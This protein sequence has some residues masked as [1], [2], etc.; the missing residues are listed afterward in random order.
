M[1]RASLISN[2]IMSKYVCFCIPIEWIVLPP[3]G[4]EVV[5]E[6]SVLSTTL[7]L[8]NT[9]IGSGILVQG[10]V[11]K[12]TGIVLAIFEYIVIGWMIYAGVDLITRCADHA[13]LFD[14][15]DIAR[16]FLGKYGAM[17]VD[18]AFVINNAGALLSYILIVGSLIDSV[19]QTFSNCNLWCC[20]VG[21]LTV[22]PILLFTVPFCLIRDFGHLA[23]ISYISIVAI[24]GSIMLVI[25]GGPLHRQQ[26]DDDADHTLLLGS[27]TGSIKAIGSIVFALGYVTG[28][29]QSYVAL[30][31]KSVAKFSAITRNT[32]LLGTAMCFVTGLM[33]YL[34]FGSAT[35]SN[36]LENFDSAV[37]AAF[38]LVVALHLILYIPG[39]FV[40]LREA[41]W[42][43]YDVN[44]H[45]QSDTQ[46]VVLTLLLILSIT[47][48]AVLLQL[49]ASNSDALAIV[50]DVTGGM[51]GSVL[52]FT[53]PA[54]IGLK[55]F[56]EDRAL[57]WRCWA[58]LVF[59]AYIII[60]V[61][62]SY[63]L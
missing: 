29:F 60:T 33:G 11:F 46:F 10:Y 35:K 38:K 49:Y 57:Y 22:T 14:Y 41:L 54:V 55:L 39:D 56:P 44:V 3:A 20:N 51:A 1:S 8:L 27:F 17:I 37:G 7:L 15:S 42:K 9:M 18:W 13:K 48:I 16:H 62:I 59:G 6:N 34:S 21:F 50:I 52:Y 28:A 30:K 36:V 2:V 4:E 12:E 61:A 58:L 24:S 63:L 53:I 40:I 47:A 26:H 31:D 19:V 45:Q 43:I 5:I 23:V 25:I 32:T